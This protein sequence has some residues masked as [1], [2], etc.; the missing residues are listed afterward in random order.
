MVES[1]LQKNKD[2]KIFKDNPDMLQLV[3]SISNYMNTP[4][5]DADEVIEER[6]RVLDLYDKTRKTNY[7]SLFS[8]LG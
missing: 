5:T 3:K 4:V 7:R 2:K 1:Y 8:K 6:T